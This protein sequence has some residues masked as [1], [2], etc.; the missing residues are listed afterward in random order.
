LNDPGRL[1][2]THL[3]HTGLVAGWSGVM[4]LYECLIIDA[5]DQ[6]Y[7]PLWRQ[8]CFVLPYSARLGVISSNFGWSLGITFNTTAWTYETVLAAHLL[9][10]G[11]FILAAC[12]HWSFWDLNVFISTSG[13]R[14]V[15][16]LNRLFGIHL[17]LASLLSFCFGIIH[18][19]G[20][21]M[22]PGMWS[23]DAFGLLGSVRSIK[24][25]FTLTQLTP[26][27][28]GVISANHIG[29]GLFGLALSVWHISVR[30]SPLLF[31]S[32]S[33]NS[34]ESNLASSIIALAFLVFV[35]ASSSWY[36]SVVYPIELLGP[37]RYHWDNGYFANYIER[38][39]NASMYLERS[40]SF[41]TLPDKLVLYDYL[42]SNPAKGGLFRSGPIIKGDGIVQNWL[43]HALF[44][45]DNLTLYVRRMPSFFETF[46]VLLL[47]KSGTVKVDIPFRRSESKFS[48]DQ[49]HV[50]V[51]FQ[52]G[53]LDG[54][55]YSTPTQV[56][57]YARKSQLG[58]ILSFDCI[59]PLSEGV[60]RTSSR[61][62]YSFTHLT[63]GFVFIFGHLWHSAR[64]LY[65]TIGS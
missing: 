49:I 52:G 34:L 15:L 16:D 26:F 5:S 53:V 2:G 57:N 64:S 61:A 65:R 20:F 24:P 1:L 43:G 33:M 36:G 60:L 55:E 58:E 56:R 35:T 37:T 11:L 48:F 22:G 21:G 18:L 4:L 45:L 41:C 19:T 62:W 6:I 14:L 17:A 46:P 9:I 63:L 31:K 7:N 44:E 23:S 54:S 27:N 29:S 32:F 30:P 39:V 59:T 28:Y 42:G 8:G 10:S 50:L 13:S 47:D 51:Y 12:W 25:V 40:V 38:R 3:T